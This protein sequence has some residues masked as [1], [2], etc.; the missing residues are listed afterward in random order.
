MYEDCFKRRIHVGPTAYGTFS[1]EWLIIRVKCRRDFLSLLIPKNNTY[2]CQGKSTMASDN[3]SY[4]CQRTRGLRAN[5]TV[6]V[7]KKVSG[8]YFP[9][10]FT[11]GWLDVSFHSDG[12]LLKL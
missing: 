2:Q 7:R 6:N 3:H 1:R 8:L 12:T 9:G 11:S 5:I 10:G 4:P